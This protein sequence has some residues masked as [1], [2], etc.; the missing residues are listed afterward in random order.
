[1]SKMPWSLDKTQKMGNRYLA[2]MKLIQASHYWNMKLRQGALSKNLHMF[3]SD[4][5]YLKYT[6]GKAVRYT[7]NF[8]VKKQ[9]L[10]SIA[11]H[12]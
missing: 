9:F 8:N 2:D 4:H 12:Q 5:Q 3:V 11:N 7:F 1:M 10:E 6:S